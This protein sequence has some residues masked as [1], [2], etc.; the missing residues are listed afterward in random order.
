[1]A[2]SGW[3]R[4]IDRLESAG[5]TV[6]EVIVV[7]KGS[8]DVLPVV[9][10][11]GGLVVVGDELV[12]MV[13]LG[14]AK[15]VVGGTVGANS[16]VVKKVG[17]PTVD[18][19]GKAVVVGAMEDVAEL[20]VVMVVWVLANVLVVEEVEMVAVVV[21]VADSS[22]VVVVVLAHRWTLSL[23]RSLSHGRTLALLAAPNSTRTA[24]TKMTL[25]LLMP[26]D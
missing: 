22:I 13:V 23:A 12:V 8:S 15:L 3:E 6:T 18:E 16:V 1:M 5:T 26:G 17:E 7:E 14:W 2:T 11:L 20:V 4:G 10:V 24:K 21:V 9:G 25:A 19:T